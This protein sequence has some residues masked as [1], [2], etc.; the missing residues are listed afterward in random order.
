MHDARTIGTMSRSIKEWLVAVTW[1]PEFNVVVFAVLLNYPWEFLQVPM[2]DRMADAA[3]WAAI[4]TCTR[5]TLG[6]GA[7]MLA[8]YWCVAAV[9]R[10][11]RWILDA[12]RTNVVLFAAVGTSITIVI[13]RLALSGRWLD[14]WT[15]S[16]LMPIVPIAGVGLTPVLQ[17]I[18]L[19][20]LVVWFVRRQLNALP[21]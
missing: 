15:Y 14:G 19:P 1:L 13:E 4:K 11:R 2:F 12:G 8:A 16:S 7:I 18:V 21:T 3:H 5:A 10:S 6:D 9:A 17:W 20:P